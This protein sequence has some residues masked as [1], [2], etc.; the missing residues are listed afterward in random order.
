MWGSGSHQPTSTRGRTFCD[1][2]RSGEELVR[3]D[4]GA[5][6]FIGWCE[7]TRVPLGVELF[8][9]RAEDVDN[10]LELRDFMCVAYVFVI[11][12]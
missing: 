7:I 3:A 2:G 6:I 9:P 11:Q 12:H 10:E 8:D 4:T 5:D 1:G